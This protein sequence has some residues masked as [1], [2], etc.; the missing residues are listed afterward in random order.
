MINKKAIHRSATEVSRAKPYDCIVLYFTL[1]P[2][3]GENSSDNVNKLGSSFQSVLVLRRTNLSAKSGKQ[4]SVIKV[5]VHLMHCSVP[6]E[7]VNLCNLLSNLH[8][9]D[10]AIQFIAL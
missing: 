1:L 6:E 7:R 4:Y 10:L 8:L 9:S 2:L 5:S 3:I